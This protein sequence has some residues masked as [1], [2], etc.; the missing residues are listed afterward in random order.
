MRVFDVIKLESAVFDV[1]RLDRKVQCNASNNKKR[2]KNQ[3]TK[4]GEKAKQVEKCQI[5]FF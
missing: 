2:C 1:I 5:I 3:K 4:T